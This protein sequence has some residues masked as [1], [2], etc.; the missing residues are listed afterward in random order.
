[1]CYTET[2]DNLCV[3]VYKK[4]EQ[5]VK[6]SFPVSLH[7]ILGKDHMPILMELIRIFKR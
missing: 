5:E 6:K 7:S 2:I 1:M 3:H 4:E